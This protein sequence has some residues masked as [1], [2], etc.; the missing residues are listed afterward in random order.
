VILWLHFQKTNA[1]KLTIPIIIQEKPLKL[2]QALKSFIFDKHFLSN[3]IFSG[4]LLIFV[5]LNRQNFST[6]TRILPLTPF[7]GFFGVIF[8]AILLNRKNKV[9]PNRF[10]DYFNSIFYGIMIGLYISLGLQIVQDL[11]KTEFFY[12]PFELP[13]VQIFGI[14]SFI[15]TYTVTYYGFT[16][17]WDN[18]TKHDR[19]MI[20][21]LI[22]MIIIP[23]CVGALSMVY[24]G[25]SPYGRILIELGGI[26]I[27]LGLVL[28]LGPLAVCIIT[29]II[30]MFFRPIVKNSLFGAS[31]V[32]IVVGWLLVSAL[33]IF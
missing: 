17:F 12:Y 25:L 16:E 32:S 2:K 23:I 22:P 28:S 13:S 7:L 20:R 19:I 8:V 15:L 18:K 21:N 33:V 1:K 4:G 9:D 3:I 26:S 11:A 14:I 24:F 31:L 30:N 27:S 6:F 10:A 29:E 5:A